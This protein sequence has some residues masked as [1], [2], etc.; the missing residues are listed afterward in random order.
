MPV[1]RAVH[2]ATIPDGH[3]ELEGDDGADDTRAAPVPA[4]DW[5]DAL[6]AFTREHRAWLAH[7]EPDDR[8]ASSARDRPLV[9]VRPEHRGAR[10]VAIRIDLGMDAADA[11]TLRIEE[12]VAVAVETT[13][14][15]TSSG[16]RIEDASGR[17]TRLRFRV[18]PPA[19]MLDGVAPGEM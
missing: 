5:D 8:A 2:A 12:P 6:D 1:E 18:E 10:V 3:V 7:V 14:D 4:E 16:L 11:T 9:D 19:A 15:G 13:P 17:L